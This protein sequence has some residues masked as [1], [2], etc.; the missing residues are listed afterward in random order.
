MILSNLIICNKKNNGDIIISLDKEKYSFVNT[1]FVY[2]T[3]VNDSNYTRK[4]IPDK[5]LASIQILKDE[6]NVI[7]NRVI[8]GYTE[9]GKKLT[10]FDFMLL[11]F[12]L[13]EMEEVIVCKEGVFQWNSSL[14]DFEFVG[15][16]DQVISMKSVT[17]NEN[18]EIQ[19]DEFSLIFEKGSSF[20]VDGEY[21]TYDINGKPIL[22][23][24]V[25]NEFTNPI[26]IPYNQSFMKIESRDLITIK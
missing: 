15:K 4:L 10:E 21:I 23:L 1:L 2:G 26:A 25:Q 12:Y 14:E 11:T 18:S 7:K 9:N 13:S 6:F 24:V 16:I 22:M 3:D 19:V 5:E 20:L 8:E 17:I